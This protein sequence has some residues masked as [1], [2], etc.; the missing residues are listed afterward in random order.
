MGKLSGESSV[1]VLKEQGQMKPGSPKC[2]LHSYRIPERGQL[3]PAPRE[4]GRKGSRGASEQSTQN[5]TAFFRPAESFGERR[6]QTGLGGPSHHQGCQLLCRNVAQ[7]H[8][9]HT[10]KAIYR[11][12]ESTQHAR[13]LPTYR[14]P[15]P[16]RGTRG[17]LT[18]ERIVKALT[19]V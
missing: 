16:P 11:S 18:R 15:P 4:G 13:R 8:C 1:S 9:V 2:S 12:A 6:S 14:S 5:S 19:Q 17:C 3:C 10:A 7:R